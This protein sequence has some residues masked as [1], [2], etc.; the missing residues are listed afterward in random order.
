MSDSSHPVSESNGFSKWELAKGWSFILLL[1]TGAILGFWWLFIAPSESKVF[2][3]QGV[4]DYCFR[5][6]VATSEVGPDEW[7]MKVCISANNGYVDEN[8]KVIH[9]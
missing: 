2:V 9:P 1:L 6:L 7:S 8:G 5:K 4:N 3:I